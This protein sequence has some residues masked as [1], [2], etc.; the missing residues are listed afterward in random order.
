MPPKRELSPEQVQEIHSLRGQLP[1]AEAKKRFGIGTTR[2]YKIWR[3]GTT[4]PLEPAVASP[5]PVVPRATASSPDAGCSQLPTVADFYS[6][7]DR[8]EARAEQ[9]TNLLV[10]VLAQL[11]KD[12]DSKSDILEEL[13]ADEQQQ[14]IA[15]QVRETRHEQT[16]VR[17]DLQKVG[18]AVEAAQKWAYISIA[19][20]LW[21]G[22]Y[23]QRP[24][25]D[26]RLLL[27]C[28]RNKS[29]NHQRWKA[30]NRGTPSTWP[31][32]RSIVLHSNSSPMGIVRRA[33]RSGGGR[34]TGF[35]ALRGDPARFFSG[36]GGRISCKCAPWWSLHFSISYG[37][38]LS[39]SGCDCLQLRLR[40]S[41]RRSAFAIVYIGLHLYARALVHRR[42]YL[43]YLRYLRCL[44]CVCLW[45][46][47]GAW[48]A[49]VYGG[50]VCVCVCVCVCGAC[51]AFVYG[52]VCVRMC[53][54]K[55][56]KTAVAPAKNAL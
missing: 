42:L 18:Q 12:D 55:V 19:A 4:P 1:A 38:R 7:L 16:E 21:S 11:S 8:L 28:R 22:K 53:A 15:E 48:V 30:R 27:S 35:V 17:M 37:L 32:P 41:C 45:C 31:S 10:Q 44:G 25:T 36:T 24:G 46:V 23:S 51:V 3:D 56:A 33:Y 49:F 20:V 14:E 29:P 5:L 2:L 26:A 9:A 40:V 52:G 39:I 50:G 43:R 6:R 13:L 34:K 54:K 47:C